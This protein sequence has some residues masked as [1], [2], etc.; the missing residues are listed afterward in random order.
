MCFSGCPVLAVALG[1][2]GEESEER[3]PST[4]SAAWPSAPPREV[5]PLPHPSSLKSL[6]SHQTWSTWP[7]GGKGS[8]SRGRHGRAMATNRFRLRSGQPGA[9]LWDPRTCK[10]LLAGGPRLRG[11]TERG[12]SGPQTQNVRA[13]L[14]PAGVLA[15]ISEDNQSPRHSGG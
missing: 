2:A 12:P 14:C 3:A 5:C 7:G 15:Q 4:F 13:R 11:L 8:D 6:I 10:T 1:S 9:G